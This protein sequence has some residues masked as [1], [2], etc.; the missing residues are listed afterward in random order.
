[1]SAKPGRKPGFF[2]A[3]YEPEFHRRKSESVLRSVGWV[4]RSDTHR[5]GRSDIRASIAAK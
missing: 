4:E 1:V 3:V 2:L 5:S